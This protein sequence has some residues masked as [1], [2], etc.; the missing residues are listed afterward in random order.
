[1]SGTWAVT[2]TVHAEDCGEGT[3]VESYHL[4][5]EQDGNNLIVKDTSGNEFRGTI[6]GNTLVWSGSY[7]EDGGTTTSS[8]NATISGNSI[9]GT[10][11]W[12]WA[13][14]VDSCSGTSEFHAAK[15]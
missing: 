15:I 12:S 3:Y 10:S 1:M 7:P 2:D 5:V 11:R 14:G 6:S 8:I 4:T 9:T 13:D